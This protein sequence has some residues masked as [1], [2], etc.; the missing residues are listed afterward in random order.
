MWPRETWPG[1]NGASSFTRN[2]SPNSR[3]SVNARHTQETGVLS[4]IRFSML[5]LIRNLLV[6]VNMDQFATKRNHFVAL[7]SSPDG[8][9]ALCGPVIR[10]RRV[11]WL[12]GR[13]RITLRSIRATGGHVAPITLA[14]LPASGGVSPAM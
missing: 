7:K 1:A 6:A 5:L 4:S 2:H 10:D 8:G 11:G 14:G 3:W 9:T 13:S 12:R